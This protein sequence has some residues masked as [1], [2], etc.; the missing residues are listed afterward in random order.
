MVFE[1]NQFYAMASLTST[2]PILSVGGLAKRYL[3]PGWRLGWILIHDRNNLL[4]HV[5]PSYNAL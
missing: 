1:P 4:V 2:V 3:V 5:R